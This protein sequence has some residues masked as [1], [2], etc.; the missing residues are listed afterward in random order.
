MKNYIEGGNVS[1]ACIEMVEC[2]CRYGVAFQHRL[3][4]DGDFVS[5]HGKQNTDRLVDALITLMRFYTY[6]KSIKLPQLCRNE[7]E[8]LAYLLLLVGD[9]SDT[10]E[11][12]TPSNPVRQSPEVQFA[13]QVLYTVEQSAEE[14]D[15]RFFRLYAAAPYLAACCMAKYA[16]DMRRAAVDSIDK[17]YYRGP[18]AMC[19]SSGNG[20]RCA[21]PAWRTSASGSTATTPPPPSTCITGRL[22]GR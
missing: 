2:M 13:L 20:R 1:S 16:D 3:N 4:S 6:C 11:H 19:P 12:L 10:L 15:L 18:R 14:N 5:N 8:F 21:S 7:P 22:S 17:A 9:V